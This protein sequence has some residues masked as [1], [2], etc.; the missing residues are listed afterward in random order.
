MS[1]NFNILFLNSCSVPIVPE[2]RSTSMGQ[3]NS[4]ALPKLY[5][6]TLIKS[7]WDCS[8]FIRG[9]WKVPHS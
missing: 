5:S 6:V 2:M 7:L 4:C 1:L 8:L 9:F 3:Q